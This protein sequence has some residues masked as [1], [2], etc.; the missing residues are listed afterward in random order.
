MVQVINSARLTNSGT[1]V[2]ITLRG[3][4]TKNLIIDKVS[5]SQVNATVHPWNSA[6]D[7]VEVRSGGVSGV[8]IP[9]NQPKTLDDTN[10]TLDPT[11]D[12]LIAFDINS[13]AGNDS[14]GRADVPQST[15]YS[16]P[17]TTRS[18]NEGSAVSFSRLRG[19][20]SRQRLPRRKIEVL[21]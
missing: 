17:A 10:Y 13:A 16:R 8:T 15:M 5:I 9:A 21:P 11:K 7:L 4:T 14:I 12:L 19:E 1:K 6:A 3:P 18:P 20:A 2:R